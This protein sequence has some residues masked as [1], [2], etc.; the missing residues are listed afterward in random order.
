MLTSFALLVLVL[1][2]ILILMVEVTLWVKR[3][4]GHSRHLR[5]YE[6]AEHQA[7]IE[8]SRARIHYMA[9]EIGDGHNDTLTIWQEYITEIYVHRGLLSHA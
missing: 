5:E 2:S 7:N 8:L 3:L 6:K 9:W 1:F 4:F